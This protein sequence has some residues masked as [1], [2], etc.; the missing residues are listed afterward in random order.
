MRF[1]LLAF[2]FSTSCAIAAESGFADLEPGPLAVGWKVV[3]QY[4]YA[5]TYKGL[6]DP[7]SG[8]PTRGE[9]AR[10]TRY[11]ASACGRCAMPRRCPANIR[12]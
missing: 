12:S 1:L 7:V 9:R 3:Q 4:D 2:F 8:E 6:I 5:R 10:P 11:S